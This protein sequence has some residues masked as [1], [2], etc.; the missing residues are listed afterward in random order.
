MR[1]VP[2][3]SSSAARRQGRVVGAAA[4]FGLLTSGVAH[5]A[6]TYTDVNAL[7]ASST[8]ATISASRGLAITPN[9]ASGS[10]EIQGY[11]QTTTS[12]TSRVFFTAT[13][14]G[15]TTP[16]A[17]GLTS[18]T[19]ASSGGSAI[20]QLVN[21][22][23]TSLAESTATMPNPGGSY[24][25]ATATFTPF[26]LDTTYNGTYTYATPNGNTFTQTQTASQFAPAAINATGNAVGLQPFTLTG[27]TSVNPGPAPVSQ[28][29]VIY[30]AATNTTTD[31]GGNP[32][33]L[34][35]FPAANNENA[36]NTSALNAISG[37][38][39]VVG[40]QGT[41][42][43]L[44]NSATPSDAIYGTPNAT[45]G[46]TFSDLATNLISSLIPSGDTYNASNATA[47]SENGNYVVGTYQYTVG[48][49]TTAYIH[50]FELTNDQSI[51]D[52][53]NLG[54]NLNSQKNVL[55]AVAVNDS[56]TVVGYGYPTSS[57]STINAFIYSNGTLSNLNSIGAPTPTLGTYAAAYGIDDAG[58]IT[59]Y[60]TTST[61]TTGGVT[62]GFVLTASVPE[63]TSAGLAV[64]AGGLLLARRR[65]RATNPA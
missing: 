21:D 7:A 61:T 48:T 3:C 40:N 55:D 37:N 30:N 65:S 24:N 26:P 19:S 14:P 22:Q 52:L 64:A 54:T 62:D 28:H 1:N 43:R 11:Y 53:G 50:S 44:A 5:G 12:T 42:A 39:I 31:I 13:P 17:T 59:G 38:N 8:G 57:S 33:G 16:Y 25:P 4:A 15:G 36:I 6:Y 29:G 47:I 20:G 41:A 27:V 60:S 18:P 51:V 23:G 35:T 63:P 46:Y 45:G 58:D 2:S 10:P 9:G 34:T 32:A 49:S 56:G